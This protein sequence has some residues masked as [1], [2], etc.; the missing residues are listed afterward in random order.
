MLA[1]LKRHQAPKGKDR[2]HQSFFR[3]R[4]VSSSGGIFVPDEH[5]LDEW[6]AKKIG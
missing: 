6:L 4:T 1:S 3:G 5:Q 2:V